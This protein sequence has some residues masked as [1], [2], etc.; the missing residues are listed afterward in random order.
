[1]QDARRATMQSRGIQIRECV[2]PVKVI[3]WRCRKTACS[4]CIGKFANTEREAAMRSSA[5]ERVT[6]RRELGNFFLATR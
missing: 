3:R 6:R 5:R 4:Y 2:S 1:M